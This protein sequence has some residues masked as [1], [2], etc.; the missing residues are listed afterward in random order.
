M[1]Q[2]IS[3]RTYAVVTTS[4]N[5]TGIR[6][7]S[8]IYDFITQLGSH[9]QQLHYNTCIIT[10]HQMTYTLHKYL[11]TDRFK[12]STSIANTGRQLNIYYYRFLIIR[13]RRNKNYYVKDY[14]RCLKIITYEKNIVGNNPTKPDCSAVCLCLIRHVAS[15]RVCHSHWVWRYLAARLVVHI[16]FDKT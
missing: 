2:E 15:N 9:L 5:L 16:A 13:Y 14:N 1:L 11:M 8:L 6:T 7:V 4:L 10:F 3:T 12:I